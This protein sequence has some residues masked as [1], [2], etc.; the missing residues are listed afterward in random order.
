MQSLISN[1]KPYIGII[2]MWVGFMCLSFGIPFW[3]FHL[4]FG[5]ASF[6]FGTKISILFGLPLIVLGS[7]W[8][9]KPFHQLTSLL[10]YM[11]AFGA[12]FIAIII[13][14]QLFLYDSLVFTAQGME[15]LVISLVVALPCWLWL[16][17][18]GFFRNR[19][20]KALP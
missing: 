16:W 6:G 7:Y 20:K 5:I 18:K 17:R 19:R 2:F 13:T 9:I 3:I 15:A 14:E 8:Q 12:S 4:L 11:L 1:Y 10:I